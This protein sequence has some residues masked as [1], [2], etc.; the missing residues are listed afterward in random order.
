MSKKNKNVPTG[1]LIRLKSD[2]S[3][4][5]VTGML[6]GSGKYGVYSINW[7]VDYNDNQN[8]QQA[9]FFEVIG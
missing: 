8:W 5:V 3:I 9:V 7:L 4:G 1:T 2:N 6:T